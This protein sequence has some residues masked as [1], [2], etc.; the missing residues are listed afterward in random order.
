MQMN[1][2]NK[3]L[4]KFSLQKVEIEAILLQRTHQ[5]CQFLI[6]CVRQ[7]ILI[8]AQASF[9]VWHFCNKKYITFQIYLVLGFIGEDIL[10]Q[11]KYFWAVLLEVNWDESKLRLRRR[12]ARFISIEN[13]LKVNALKSVVWENL[14]EII[15]GESKFF[16]K[17]KINYFGDELMLS[18]YI[19]CRK[20]VRLWIGNFSSRLTLWAE[21]FLRS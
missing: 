21:T 14:V 1:C 10:V 8:A 16:C 12:L 5:G 9:F 2:G 15:W 7:K 13:N 18:S 17:S 6:S 20:T 19:E 11:F 3:T 4:L